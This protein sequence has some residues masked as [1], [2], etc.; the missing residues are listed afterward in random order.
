ML[1]F[2][3]KKFIINIVTIQKKQKKG[4]KYRFT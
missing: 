2:L 3:Q 4:E 1:T